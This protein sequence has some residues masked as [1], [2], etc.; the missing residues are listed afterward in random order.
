MAGEKVRL[1][2]RPMRGLLVACCLLA[3]SLTTACGRQPPPVGRVEVE[4]DEITLLYPGIAEYRLLWTAETPLEGRQGELRAAVHLLGRKGAV[5]RTFD[6]PLGFEWTPGATATV[7]RMLYQSALAPPLETGTYELR[8]G[9]YDAS[10]HHWKLS[11]AGAAIRVKEATEGFPA[12]YFSPEWE[13]IDSG[14]DRQVLGRRWLRADGVIRLGE[15]TRPGTLWLQLAIPE[16]REGELEL[17]LEE[18]ATAPEVIVRSSCGDLSETRSGIGSHRVML[19]IVPPADET[20]PPE[21]EISLDANYKLIS[22]VD[23]TRLT[24]G[25]ESLSWLTG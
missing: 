1:E 20:L 12:F 2:S 7:E 5:L 19:A 4:P 21:C 3:V 10:G 15:L 17:V 22:I 8:I 14:T 11:S 6:H 13:P 16:P 24:V 25:L 18:G 9:L 23:R